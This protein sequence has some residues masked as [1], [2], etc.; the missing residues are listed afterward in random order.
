MRPLRANS[1]LNS[2]P[3]EPP[4]TGYMN[5]LSNDDASSGRLR[6]ANAFRLFL[7]HD[8]VPFQKTSDKLGQHRNYLRPDSQ[9]HRH[10]IR[11]QLQR[12][13]TPEPSV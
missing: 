1:V 6:R 7:E 3:L 9:V 12:M 8:I 13:H 11:R 4:Y 10:R 5:I 2:P